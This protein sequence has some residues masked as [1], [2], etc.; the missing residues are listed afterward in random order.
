MDNIFSKK[1][2]SLPEPN[3]L[4]LRGDTVIAGV[5]G[6]AD[7]ICLLFLLCGLRESLGITVHAVHVNHGI[8]AEA[9]E[10]EA[11]VK[12]ICGKWNVPFTAV[13]EEVPALSKQWKCSEEEAGR[14]VRYEAFEKIADF[15]SSKEEIP[16][17]RIKIAVAHNLNDNAETVLFRLF[18]GTGIKGLTGIP[19][20]R[21]GKYRIIRPLLYMERSEIEKVLRENDIPWVS[22]ATN[23]L[24]FYSRNRIRHTIL[25]E[26]EKTVPEAARHIAGTAAQ[27]RE[28]EDLLEKLTGE[29][30]A[31]CVKV[32]SGQDKKAPDGSDH[33]ECYKHE[34]DAVK[35]PGYHIAIQ[36][37]LIHRCLKE[38]SCG[39]KD[40]GELQIEQILGLLRGNENRRIDLARGITAAREYDRIVIWRGKAE[41]ARIGNERIKGYELISEIFEI[42]ELLKN[43][44]RFIDNISQDDGSNQ[45]TKWLDYDKIDGQVILRTRQTGDFFYVQ[46]PDGAFGKKSVKDFMIDKK[47]PPSERDDI[48]LAAA[49]D[50]VL[51][52]IGYRISDDLKISDKTEK[53]LKLSLKY[54]NL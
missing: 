34:I 46:K 39:G 53:V 2:G 7:S 22:D 49:G 36:K 3:N 21:E 17:D 51:W 32:F 35:L 25:P 18:R 30:F 13:R 14:K 1:M 52:I 24:D 42:E 48:P 6:G 27:L 43:D 20:V 16:S 41:E 54:N 4:I 26:A 8:R 37:R 50:K 38:L 28:I 11:F 9:G 40:L 19:S 44:P 10:D 15:I 45:C 12:E 33:G 29:C 23:E 47:I 31:E 5:S